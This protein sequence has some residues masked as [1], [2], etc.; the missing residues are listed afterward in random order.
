MQQSVP[1]SR[2][3]S[4]FRDFSGRDYDIRTLVGMLVGKAVGTFEGAAVGTCVQK[5]S[6]FRD[7]SGRE[8]DFHHI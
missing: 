5:I 4:G 1:V 2:K 8:Y 3:T 6:C 7:F